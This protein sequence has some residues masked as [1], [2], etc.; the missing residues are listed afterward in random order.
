MRSW[1]QI[2]CLLSARILRDGNRVP[3]TNFQRTHQGALLHVWRYDSEDEHSF[4][5]VLLCLNL[6]AMN[7]RLL[8]AIC[9]HSSWEQTRTFLTETRLINK[10]SCT[11]ITNPHRHEVWFPFR[12]RVASRWPIGPD[13]YCDRFPCFSGLWNGLGCSDQQILF[14]VDCRKS[15]AGIQGSHFKEGGLTFAET[16]KKIFFLRRAITF[17]SGN[18]F[19]WDFLQ[20]ISTLS[21]NHES[22]LHHEYLGREKVGIYQKSVI[23]YGRTWDLLL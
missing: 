5:W 23:P 2:K 19:R 22:G 6:L 17:C 1:I 9:I 13:R 18:I 4:D 11:L 21:E 3:Y 15:P 16:R 8:A 12:T 20:K 14:F 10:K 7:I